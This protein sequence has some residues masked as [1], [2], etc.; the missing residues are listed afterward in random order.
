MIASML[1]PLLCEPE[2][3]IID[4]GD[5][6]SEIYFIGKGGCQSWRKRL[7]A[8]EE[9]ALHYLRVRDNFGKV[10]MILSTVAR[11]RVVSTKYTIL[12]KLEKRQFGTITQYFAGFYEKLKA[13][14]LKQS[15]PWKSKLTKVLRKTPYFYSLG[16][17]EMSNLV[18]T[19]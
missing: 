18:Y 12:G 5:Y 1:K 19:F 10:P 14:A 11:R 16:K 9:K 2:E 7:S 4:Y 15:E 6:L 17:E 8:R 3:V 13:S